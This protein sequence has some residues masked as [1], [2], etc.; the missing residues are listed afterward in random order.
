MNIE[1]ATGIKYDNGEEYVILKKGVDEYSIDRRKKA[2][3]GGK[4]TGRDFVKV[5][6]WIR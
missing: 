1:L 5:A 4:E 3:R 6:I 2:M